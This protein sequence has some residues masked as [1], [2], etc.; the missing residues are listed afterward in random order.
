MKRQRGIES[1]EINDTW[2]EHKGK[3]LIYLSL[4][5]RK[6]VAFEPRCFMKISNLK[7]DALMCSLEE[8]EDESTVLESYDVS[9]LECAVSLKDLKYSV[10]F[11]T[12]PEKYKT[13][14]NFVTTILQDEF[15]NGSELKVVV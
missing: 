5:S 14:W 12:D 4:G 15:S 7:F 3:V 9:D 1:V 2:T 10:R 11:D 8:G 13:Y 6:G